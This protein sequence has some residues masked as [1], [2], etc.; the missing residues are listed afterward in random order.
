MDLS[1]LNVSPILSLLAIGTIAGIV[2]GIKRLFDKDYKAFTIILA[3]GIVG[4]LLGLIL[5]F[6]DGLGLSVV[7]GTVIGF[8]T[9][10]YVTIVQ[11]I[12]EKY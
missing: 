11:N 9:T 6:N 7:M 4:A 3:S 2:E 1:L 8:S 12:G 10:G 5:P